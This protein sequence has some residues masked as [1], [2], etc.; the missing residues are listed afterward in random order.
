MR[1]ID[2]AE[3]GQAP[4]LLAG[5]RAAEAVLADGEWHDHDELLAA[6]VETGLADRTAANLLIDARRTP[7]RV[8]DSGHRG[9]KRKYRLRLD[10]S[11]F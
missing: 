8:E 3:A 2:A 4:R 11:D 9:R 1:P 6:I 10:L 5:W 7:S